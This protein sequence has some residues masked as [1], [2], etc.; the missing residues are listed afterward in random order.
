MDS[1]PSKRNGTQSWVRRTAPGPM[2]SAQSPIQAAK[3][4][5]CAFTPEGAPVALGHTAEYVAVRDDGQEVRFPVSGSAIGAVIGSR[6]RLVETSGGYRAHGRIGRRGA[7]RRHR[8]ATV[9]RVSRW[10]LAHDGL[11]LVRSFIEHHG[12]LRQ[13]VDA[14]LH[15]GRQG[16]FSLARLDTARDLRL[17]LQRTALDRHPWRCDGLNL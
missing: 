9:D 15:H 4:A 3:S 13:C 5:V 2:T 12:L 16:R 10:L 1:M 8:K 6:L 11:R 17:R 14:G 7:L